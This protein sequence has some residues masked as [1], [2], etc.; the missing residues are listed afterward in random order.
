MTVKTQEE[1]TTI[2]QQFYQ[3]LITNAILGRSA[4]IRD[5]S[6]KR[7]ID[8]ECGYVSTNQL[9]VVDFKN[10]YDRHPIATRVVQVLPQECWSVSPEISETDD[11]T[12]ETKF[13]KAWKELSLSL[14]GESKFTRK[15]GSPIWEYLQRV[16]ELSGIGYF[17][18][19]FL[20]LNDGLELNQPAV[21][22]EKTNLLFMRAFDQSQV[23]ITKF[24]TDPSSPR[25]G[26]PE[27]YS[28]SFSSPDNTGGGIGVQDVVRKVHW[29]RVIHIADNIG[30]NEV[31]GVPRQRPVWNRL[32]DLKKLYGGSAEMYWKGAFP[33]LSLETH[34]S[35]GGNVNIDT[36]ALKSTVD[37]FQEGL[38][39]FLTLNGMAAKSL[40]PQVVDPSTQI[41]TQINAICIVL[42]TPKRIFLGSER[43]ELSS[44]E[45]KDTWNR[46][47][48]T[49]QNSYLTPRVVVPLVDRLIW[50]KVLP[51]PQSYQVC[52]PDLDAQTEDEK[53]SVAIKKVHALTK[54]VAGDVELI[55]SAEDFYTKIMNMPPEEAEIILENAIEA[56]E[57]TEDREFNRQIIELKA[58]KKHRT[59]IASDSDKKDLLETG[60][61]EKT[62]KDALSDKLT[63]RAEGK[64][65]LNKLTSSRVAD[66]DDNLEPDLL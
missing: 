31:F 4:F 63:G 19:L 49:R 52:W 6:I 17:G 9:T 58:L 54:Y 57:E 61:K 43:G 15:E 37:D 20:G 40:A 24:E 55:M 39:R 51:T 47:L 65:E 22:S 26:L 33:G 13:E 21:P 1:S 32:W 5:S 29:T 50:L 7:D 66:A 41:E 62:K 46:R 38:Q 56:F 28:I 11:A 2:N 53:A 36:K 48:K 18:V 25:F 14:T 42:A 60:E 3:E 8:K 59:P 16:D 45:D 27:E 12:E 23:Q 44:S 30:S 35:L 10:F 64:R 34:P